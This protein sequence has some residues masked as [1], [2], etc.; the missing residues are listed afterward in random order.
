MLPS[1]EMRSAPPPES[2][3]SS[4]SR[5]LSPLD[6]QRRR[7]ADPHLDLH[8]AVDVE[9]VE[10]AHVA[11]FNGGLAVTLH[12]VAEAGREADVAVAIV[13]HD[14]DGAAGEGGEG[15]HGDDG[16]GDGGAAHDGTSLKL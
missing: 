5:L 13:R 9:A 7:R 8:R 3:R 6:L 16:E 10:V 15:G 4:G 11:L 2:V 12:R 1:T 14:D